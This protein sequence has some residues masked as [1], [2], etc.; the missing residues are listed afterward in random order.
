LVGFNGMLVNGAEHSVILHLS[1]RLLNAT[2]MFAFLFSG[3]LLPIFSRMIK[4][5]QSVEPMVQ[6]AF[7]LLVVPAIVIATCSYFFRMEIMTMLYA[8]TDHIEESARVFGVLMCCFVPIASTYI[9][10]TLLTANGSLKQLNIMAS[11]GMIINILLNLFL[12]PRMQVYGSAI[13]SLSTQFLTAF[14]Q[15][16]MVQYLFRFKINY[17]LL[18]SLLLFVICSITINYFGSALHIGWISRF[19]L[20][21][22]FCF[23]I[24]FL[25]RLISI[26]NLIH[27]V[28]YGE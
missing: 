2:T 19:F 26:R 12:I 3:L 15:V 17:R 6:L 14:A 7:S 5:K 13:S 24:A 4:L 23:A 25:L 11:T 18:G 22:S 8:G 9:F 1:Y 20:C 21:S 16:L 27:I 10:G 28:K